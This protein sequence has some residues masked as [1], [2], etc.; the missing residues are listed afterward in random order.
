MEENEIQNRLISDREIF[1][2]TW[3]YIKPQIGKFILALSLMGLVVLLDAIAPLVSAQILGILNVQGKVINYGAVVF[4]ALL[5]LAAIIISLVITYI[6]VILLQKIGQNIIYA[7]R[8]D[9]FRHIENLSISQINEIPV[10]TL[11]TRVCND[12]NALNELFTTI[13]V[14]L[15]KNSISLVITICMMFVLDVELACYLCAFIPFI[16]VLSFVFRKNSKAAYRQVRKHISG[17]NAFLSENLEGMKI[18]Q[19]FNQEEKKAEEFKVANNR[20][21]KARLKSVF[22]FGI[23]RP[24]ITLLYFSAIAVCFFVGGQ[25]VLAN[26]LTIETVWAFYLYISRFFNP[27]Q[28]LADQFNGL[29]RAFTASERLYVLLD[30][31]PI[32]LDAEDAIEVEH[33]DGEIEFKNVWFAYK[34]DDWILQDVSFKINPKQTVAFVGATGAGKTTILSLIVRN[35]EIQKGEILIDGININKI[36]IHSLRKNIGQMLQDVFMFAGTI[37]S[38]ITL[39]DET[40]TDEEVDKAIRY[41]N[42]DKFVYRYSKGLDEPVQE[43]GGNFSSGQ[44]QLLSFARTVVHK[45]QILILDEATANID[46]ETE[47]LIQESLLNMMNIGTMLIVAHRLSTIQHADNIICLQKGRIIEQGNHQQLLKNKGY[48]YNLYRLQFEDQVK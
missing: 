17:M 16:A 29:Q 25:R 1:K 46:T 12:T 10:G 4:W 7:L 28:T 32:V 23:F 22:I 5:F 3:K 8:T 48:Y 20:L 34:G 6:E 36:K 21:K 30:V 31:Q 9:V 40:I 37:K 42:A 39:R 47:V 44:R 45:P 41:V 14:N 19:I 11:V 13:L 33:F 24:S 26:A 2:R 43:K 18:T 35:Y 38:N 27:I 15:L